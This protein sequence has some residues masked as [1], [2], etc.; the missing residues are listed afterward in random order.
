[1]AAS[2]LKALGRR[3][4]EKHA[5]V[6]RPAGTFTFFDQEAARYE[7]E[8][9]G[10]GEELNA[11][12]EKQGVVSAAEE[13]QL[14]LQQ[15]AQFQA[16][17]E[18][19]RAGAREAK[20]REAALERE[21]RGTPERQVTVV[22][23]QDNAQLLALLETTV[24]NLELKR[25]DMRMKYAPTY[26]PVKEVEEELAAAE[27]ALAYAQ[28]T[29]VEETTTDRP[30]VQDWLATELAKAR[31]D[32]AAFETAANSTA[33]I[34]EHYQ[35]SAHELDGKG[36]AQDELIRNLKAAEDNYLLYVHKRE[37]AR[38]S[39]ALDSKRIVNV[40]IA[41]EATV[42]ALPTLHL[43][44]LL[45]GSL[46]GAGTLSLSSA[47]ALD[48]MDASFRSAEELRRYLDV[49]VLAAIPKPLAERSGIP[50][51]QA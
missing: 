42:P 3:Y 9:R 41:E 48:R 22:K 7:Q 38:I 1:L 16:Q 39:D 47:Y 2:V 43:G 19:Q 29:P 25:S 31:A 20:S 17:F 50:E 49:D 28:K 23:K 4:Q 6:H 45:I 8:L 24:L 37:E 26:A 40:G 14:V 36:T 34:V 11:F 21:I 46:F 13:K 15:T 18:Q 33:K 30:P 51:G 32:Y 5:I 44:W 12:D 35:K 27:K 10:A